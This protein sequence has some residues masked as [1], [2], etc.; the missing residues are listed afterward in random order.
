MHSPKCVMFVNDGSHFTLSGAKPKT[1]WV[2]LAMSGIDEDFDLFATP[3]HEYCRPS[4]ASGN[5][6]PVAPPRASGSWARPSDAEYSQGRLIARRLLAR[7]ASSS[8]PQSLMEEA[9][10]AQMSL[11]PQRGRA[12]SNQSGRGRPPRHSLSP[13]HSGGRDWSWARPLSAPLISSPPRK[14]SR[15]RKTWRSCHATPGKPVS[16][17]LHQ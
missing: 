2:T 10:R 5:I 12:A 14:S 16:N 15:S 3:I 11:V 7:G 1:I 8:V 13:K 6:T 4:I 9:S 17:P